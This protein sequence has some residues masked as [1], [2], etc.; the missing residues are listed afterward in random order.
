M[1]VHFFFDIAFHD[2]SAKV[3]GIALCSC[4]IET[5]CPC[6]RKGFCGVGQGENK[7]FSSGK[8]LDRQ[9]QQ[10]LGAYIVAA[11]MGRRCLGIVPRHCPYGGIFLPEPFFGDA[12]FHFCH[13]SGV[14][15]AVSP[16]AAQ[17]LDRQ[18][19]PVF[20]FRFQPKCHGV[21]SFLLGRA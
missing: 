14:F 11:Q 15:S 18:S 9:I 8:C 7:I 16:C 19:V 1:S 13:K 6:L 20:C 10:P 5:A 21:P 2:G 3:Y 12:V 4:G 17:I